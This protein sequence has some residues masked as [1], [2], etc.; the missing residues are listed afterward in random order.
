[1]A[2]ENQNNNRQVVKDLS[3]MQEHL[4]AAKTHINLVETFLKSTIKREKETRRKDDE[5]GA[6]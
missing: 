4:E 3:H 5:G 6:G 2:E 1:M